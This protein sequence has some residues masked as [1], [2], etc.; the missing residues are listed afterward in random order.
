MNN[1]VYYKIQKQDENNF[2][3]LLNVISDIRYRKFYEP[4]VILCEE[5]AEE[6][7]EY[8]P[9]TKE[10]IVEDNVKSIRNLDDLRDIM[11]NYISTSKDYIE[12]SNKTFNQIYNIWRNR[13]W[14]RK[15]L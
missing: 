8:S 9:F 10:E 7:L 5:K 1:Y 13:I 14:E 3:N 15:E 4:N 6:N 2:D 12:M 11:Y